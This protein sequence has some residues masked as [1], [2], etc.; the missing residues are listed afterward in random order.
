MADCSGV[1]LFYRQSPRYHEDLWVTVPP[2]VKH[3][4]IETVA[5]LRIGAVLGLLFHLPCHRRRKVFGAC[6]GSENGR[7]CTQGMLRFPIDPR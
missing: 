5:D 2:A 6:C 7:R 3:A 4:E 1:G